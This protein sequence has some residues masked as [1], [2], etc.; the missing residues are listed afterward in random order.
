[1]GC[2][3]VRAFTVRAFLFVRKILLCRIPFLCFISVFH[4]CL[5]FWRCMKNVQLQILPDVFMERE[6]Q[7]I[8]IWKDGAGC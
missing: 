5:L 2:E 7:F 1:M 6:E 3:E 4:S 8:Y